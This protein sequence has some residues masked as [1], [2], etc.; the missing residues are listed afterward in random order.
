MNSL[1]ALSYSIHDAVQATGLGRTR[2]YAAIKEGQLRTRHF[3]RRTV[4]LADDLKAFL[5]SLPE[6]E[7]A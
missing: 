1:P 4:I 3:G 2:L 7:V 5:A 6:R